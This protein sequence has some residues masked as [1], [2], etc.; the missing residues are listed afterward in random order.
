MQKDTGLK[1][2]YRLCVKFNEKE[3]Q[4]FNKYCQKYHITNK[5]RFIRE[6]IMKAI[7]E[8]MVEEDY[9]KL[10]PD[11]DGDLDGPDQEIVELED[12]EQ[13]ALNGSKEPDPHP[14]LFD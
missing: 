7:I 11:L 10:F 8:K 4:V 3:L 13:T 12:F 9:P 14:R 6:A 2:T 1:R 5:S